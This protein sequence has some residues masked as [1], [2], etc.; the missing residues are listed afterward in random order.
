MS[1]LVL[2]LL[3]ELINHSRFQLRYGDPVIR[4]TVPLALA[5]T[6]LSNPQLSIMETLSKFS[7]DVDIS[8]ARNSIVAL[9]LISAGT[10]NARIAAILRNLASYYARDPVSLFSCS[11]LAS[12][13][14]YSLF[15]P[16]RCSSEWHRD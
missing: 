4:R 8:I 6:S 14:H 11:L 16:H 2:H 9:G 13:N 7:H 10:N 12:I 1:F 3:V 15:R 5:L